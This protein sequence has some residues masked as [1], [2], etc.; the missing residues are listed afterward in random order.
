ML[1]TD[2]NVDNWGI[3][4]DTLG[5]LSLRSYW[6]ADNRNVIVGAEN[7]VDDAV[8]LVVQ[9]YYTPEKDTIDVGIH[10]EKVGL[11]RL[12]IYASDLSRRLPGICPGM[13]GSQEIPISRIFPVLSISIR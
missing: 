8:P 9:G 10:L 1:I 6:D 5:S 7:R 12:G 4:R 2:F 11:E 13:C 3:N